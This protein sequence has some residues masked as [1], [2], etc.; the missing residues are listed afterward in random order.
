MGLE[1]ASGAT[2]SFPRV[3]DVSL[4]GQPAACLFRGPEA[5]GRWPSS[6]VS[7]LSDGFSTSAEEQRR[8][9]A[10]ARQYQN[11]GKGNLGCREGERERRSESIGRLL[12]GPPDAGELWG[13]LAG[14]SLCLEGADC[15]PGQALDDR[16]WGRRLQRPVRGN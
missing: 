7:S 1:K 12:R 14:P 4:T 11:D 3:I 6:S 16:A 15:K 13:W 9:M 10:L 5:C 2:V 8:S